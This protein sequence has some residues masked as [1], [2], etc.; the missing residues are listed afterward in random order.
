MPANIKITLLKTAKPLLQPE[1]LSKR[2]VLTAKGL[3]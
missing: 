1:K 2:D 3:E